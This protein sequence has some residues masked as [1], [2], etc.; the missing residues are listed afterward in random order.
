MLV[1][2]ISLFSLQEAIEKFRKDFADLGVYMRPRLFGLPEPVEQPA[3][4]DGENG[5][6]QQLSPASSS[7]DFTPTERMFLKCEGNFLHAEALTASLAYT[8]PN[9][10]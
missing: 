4:A 1:P 3:Q 6:P 7:S 5:S 2:R 10:R 9:H 8:A